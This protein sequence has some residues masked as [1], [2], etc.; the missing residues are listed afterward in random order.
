MYS[1]SV[2][3]QAIAFMQAF[4]WLFI[5]PA[6][7][8]RGIQAR[9]VARAMIFVARTPLCKVIFESDELHEMAGSV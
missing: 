4:G 9:D 1:A 7:K 8:F 5:G 2:K 6:R 3:K